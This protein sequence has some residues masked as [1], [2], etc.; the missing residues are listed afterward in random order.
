MACYST[1]N[2]L[3]KMLLLLALGRVDSVA[4]CPLSASPESATTDVVF[5]LPDMVRLLFSE[6]AFLLLYE[7]VPDLVRVDDRFY[8]RWRS[9]RWPCQCPRW[10]CRGLKSQYASRWSSPCL[11]CA[12][13][14][15][16]VGVSVALFHPVGWDP[17]AEAWCQNSGQHPALKRSFRTQFAIQVTNRI[18]D[19]PLA[20]PQ[21]TTPTCET[22]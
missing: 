2:M 8:P 12:T 20:Q 17:V 1:K 22:G 10:R 9:R 5:L 13:V 16:S 21:E 18:Q 6:V 7:L 4:G 15:G 14:A 19:S 11:S 3:E